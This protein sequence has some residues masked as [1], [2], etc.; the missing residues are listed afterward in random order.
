MSRDAADVTGVTLVEYRRDEYA[1]W[2]QK[3][4]G[5]VKIRLDGIPM[6]EPA[7]AVAS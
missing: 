4:L 1:D 2:E 3:F 7:A 5:E 6:G